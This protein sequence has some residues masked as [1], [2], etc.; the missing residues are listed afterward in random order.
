[1]HKSDTHFVSVPSRNSLCNGSCRGLCSEELLDSFSANGKAAS[2]TLHIYSH[3]ASP[4]FTV[5]IEV[6]F[7]PQVKK[8]KT[9]TKKKYFKFSCA[10]TKD[11]YHE[12]LNQPQ[13]HH[14]THIFSIIHDLLSR[15]K[16]SPFLKFQVFSNRWNLVGWKIL[17]VGRVGTNYD[18]AEGETIYNTWQPGFSH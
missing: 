13:I 9:I 11:Y 15:V 6:Y 10:Q 14:Y 8:K 17:E 18:S 4:V 16:I 12:S 2:L 1:M 7:Y 3:T 5:N